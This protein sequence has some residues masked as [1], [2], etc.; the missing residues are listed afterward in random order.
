MVRLARRSHIITRPNQSTEL[1]SS[2]I[3]QTTCLRSSVTPMLAGP[4]GR[5]PSGMWRSPSRPPAVVFATWLWDHHRG[6]APAGGFRHQG[7]V[8]RFESGRTGRLVTAFRQPL[9]TINVYDGQSR[10]A[11]MIYCSNSA[12]GYIHSLDATVQLMSQLLSRKSC[13][14]YAHTRTQA[15]ASHISWLMR[16]H[17]RHSGQP[18]TCSQAR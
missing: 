13:N 18:P 10:I 14:R 5:R 17:M 4:S 12:F 8:Y 9:A 16:V 11:P 15:L 7:S 2:F 3:L 6:M 1:R